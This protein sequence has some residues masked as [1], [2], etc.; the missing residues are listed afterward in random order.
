M[1]ESHGRSEAELD[2]WT[3]FLPSILSAAHS[4]FLSTVSFDN[5]YGPVSKAGMQGCDF[6]LHLTG[7]EEE[8]PRA[9]VTF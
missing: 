9:K 5:H 4:T 2:C 7:P 8:T 6:Y 1:K 3:E